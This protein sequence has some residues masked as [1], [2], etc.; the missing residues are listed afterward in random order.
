MM[1]GLGRRILYLGA[2]SVIVTLLLAPTARTQGLQS[3]DDFQFQE[4][5]QTQLTSNPSDP[6]NL[7]DDGNG[8]ACEDLPRRDPD[9]PTDQ[10][11]QNPPQKSPSAPPDEKAQNPPQ[12][13]PNA[14]DD[15]GVLMKAGGDLPLPEQRATSTADDTDAP[16]PLWPATLIFI[17]SSLLV[18]LVFRLISHR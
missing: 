7:D 3:C 1:E 8:L 17:S 10:T 2:L 12:K 4:D 5:A 13:P 11:A 16:F 14:P 9:A 18:L 6:N 15:E